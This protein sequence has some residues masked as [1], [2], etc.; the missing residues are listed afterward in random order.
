M[1]AWCRRIVRWLGIVCTIDGPI[2]AA[3]ENSPAVVS[4]H[5]TYLDILVYSATRPFVMVAKS[6]VRH[7]PL[8]GWITAQAGTIYVQR[9]D[10]KGGRTQTYD[11]VNAAMA[12]AFRSGLPVLFFPE[13]TTS[14]GTS[15]VLPFRRG[16]FHSVLRAGVQLKTAAVAYSLDVPDDETSLANHVCFVG[17]AEFGPHLFR[18]LGI[19]GLHV[20]VC[21]GEQAV[22][23][24]DRFALALR[25]QEHVA[26]HYDA[27]TSGMRVVP[28]ATPDREGAPSLLRVESGQ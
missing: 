19:T 4:N 2:P 1:H 12:E 23:G 8:I 25:A 3:G 24:Q 21:F 10:V 16:L 22:E 28:A 26:R 18:C 6:E 13:G 27:L 20:H 5:L 17:D 11:E 15:G 14:D 9:A 7:W